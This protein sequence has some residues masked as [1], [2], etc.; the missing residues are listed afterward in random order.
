MVKKS[1]C[2]LGSSLFLHR[3]QGDIV[4]N[5]LKLFTSDRPER[6]AQQMAR[7]LYISRQADDP[8]YTEKVVINSRGMESW[9]LQ[10]LAAPAGDDAEQLP[11][12]QANL[13]FVLPNALLRFALLHLDGNCH[14]WRELQQTTADGFDRSVLEWRIYALLTELSGGECDTAYQ[15]L[16]AYLHGR[17]GDP[18]RRRYQLAREIADTFDQYAIYRPDLLAAWRHGRETEALQHSHNAWQPLLFRQLCR[19]S[20]AD[21]GRDAQIHRFCQQHAQL[22]LDRHQLRR[23]WIFG[24]SG[25]A[26]CYLQFLRALACQVEV[27]LFVR[28]PSP[29]YWLENWN[30]PAVLR[31]QRQLAETGSLADEVALPE[32]GDP[33]LTSMGVLVYDFLNEIL[34]QCG[35]D[36]PASAGLADPSDTSLFDSD[37]P[38]AC[39]CLGAVQRSIWQNGEAEADTEWIQTFLDGQDRSLTVHSCHSQMREI[40]L[41]RDQLLAW[42]DG[43]STD[44]P[45]QRQPRHVV[46]M[47]PDIETYVPYIEAVFNRQSSQAPGFIP[48]TIADR[49]TAAA[50]AV[51]QAFLQLLQLPGLRFRVSE[52]FDLLSVEPVARAYALSSDNLEQ[53]QRWASDANIRWGLDKQHRE[54]LQFDALGGANSWDAGLD[55]LFAGYAMADADL[56]D[57]AELS[58]A[59]IAAHLEVEGSTAALLGTL[60]QVIAD[61]RQLRTELAASYPAALWQERLTAV[62]DRFFVAD[63]SSYAEIAAIRQALEQLT[64][65]T[66]AAALD[67]ALPTSVVAAYLTNA[68]QQTHSSSL[69]CRGSVT[70]CSLLPMRSI[71]ADFI[72]LLGMNDASF[73]RQ[74]LRRD[75]NLIQQQPRRGDRSRRLD[76]RYMFLE[77]LL[78]ARYRL[79]ISY[80]GRSLQDNSEQ[81]PSVLVRELLAVL[82]ERTGVDDKTF[83]P[84][85]VI[86]HPL[87]S[88]SAR[89]FQNDNARQLFSYCAAAAAAATAFYAQPELGKPLPLLFR[90]GDKLPPPAADDPLL[91]PTVEQLAQFFTDPPQYLLRQRLGL[92]LKID[93]VA[94]VDDEPITLD[95]LTVY[96]LNQRIQAV[97]LPIY[98][99]RHDA[100]LWLAA[101]DRLCRRL[102]AEGCLPA[103]VY[104]QLWLEEQWEDITGFL[105]KPLPAAAGLTPAASF[106]EVLG[107]PSPDLLLQVRYSKLKDKDRVQALVRHLAALGEA[108]QTT[109]IV[110][111]SDKTEV[112]HCCDHEQR[113]PAVRDQHWALLRALYKW[114]LTAPLPLLP[115][116]AFAYARAKTPAQA[117]AE[118]DEAWL[119]SEQ[120][121]AYDGIEKPANRYCFGSDSLCGRPAAGELVIATE[122]EPLLIRFEELAQTLDA[123]WNR[124]Q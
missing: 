59:E 82:Q 69:F 33:L 74:D 120:N 107:E 91:T 63:S 40:E 5:G 51:V 77:A 103:G 98:R 79:H 75:F 24:V 13:Q 21:S 123:I 36:D 116:P 85:A 113:S 25:M 94:L 96:S 105:E 93:E 49:T 70:F 54:H 67:Q 23:V 10:S 8:F 28:N 124:W 89:Y 27:H 104:G 1:S 110:A 83:F 15:P 57:S 99:Q 117:V 3:T 41:L 55:R 102:C 22:N 61:L 18:Q 32:K 84:A 119:G 62:L 42:F 92:N 29:Q 118:A 68:M 38:S 101:R 45:Q 122:P 12:I 106:G 95:Q 20:A 114:G 111:G 50:S 37:P 9:L 2:Q 56:D 43:D 78:S 108:P 80:Q 14:Q 35:G 112:L 16:L 100:D 65:Y 44:G 64:G 73:P 60:A 66:E 39:N 109:T 17:A 71:P 72:W 115:K 58:F 4:L 76:D 19:D 52:L 26:P 87:H 121:P 6:L 81:P 47:A 86:Q 48:Y 11:H 30:R 46:V 34:D 97:Q 90:H 7:L 53:L 88:F 31:L